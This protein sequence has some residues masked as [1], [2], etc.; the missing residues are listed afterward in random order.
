MCTDTYCAPALP[1]IITTTWLPCKDGDQRA[2]ALYRRHYSSYKY[3]DRRRDDPG[4]RNRHLIVGPGE[5]LVM[6]TAEGDALW[7]WRKFIDD[8][9]QQGVNCAVFRNESQFRSSDLILEAETL[10]QRRWPGERMYTYV[11]PGSIRSSNPG[12]CFQVAGWKKCG[13][14]KRRNYII[15]EKYPVQ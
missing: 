9:G 8:S 5:K 2:A 11:D 7:V 10:A 15:L 1:G 12:Y 6:I 3:A 13:R 4:Y 14:T